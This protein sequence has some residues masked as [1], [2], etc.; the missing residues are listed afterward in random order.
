MRIL[1]I[2]LALTL[3]AC[4]SGG[5]ASGGMAQPASLKMAPTPTREEICKDLLQQ[6]RFNDDGSGSCRWEKQSA[7]QAQIDLNQYNAFQ[8][9]FL[10]G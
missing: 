4:D 3:T 9:H 2:T 10:A 6:C 7:E 5:T 1:L 8:C